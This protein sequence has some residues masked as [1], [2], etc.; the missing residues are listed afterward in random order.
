MTIKKYSNPD[1]ALIRYG[2]QTPSIE[3]VHNR[4]A[5]ILQLTSSSMRMQGPDSLKRIALQ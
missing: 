2:Y 5:C 1:P 3:E 4:P